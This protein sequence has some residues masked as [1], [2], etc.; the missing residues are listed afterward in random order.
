MI[1]LRSGQ[2]QWIFSSSQDSRT[3]GDRE[4]S[5]V[6]LCRCGRV[7]QHRQD[8][9]VE[10]CVGRGLVGVKVIKVKKIDNF[11]FTFFFSQK[12]ITF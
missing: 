12:N 2:Q 5:F 3:A 6:V 11:M 9:A 4:I 8:S 10:V 1:M 7:L